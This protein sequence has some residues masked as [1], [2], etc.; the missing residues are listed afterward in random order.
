MSITLLI[1]VIVIAVILLVL[2][3]LISRP[4]AIGV[5]REHFINEWNDIIA[6]SKDNKSRPLSIVHA[7][8]LL[9]EALRC[10]GY[11]GE[12]MAERLV[13]AKNVIRQRESVWSAHKMRNKIAHESAFEPSEKQVSQALKAYQSAFKDLGV[14]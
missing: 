9:D 4:A 10:S 8:K 11:K 7:D 6:L 12:T 13:S 5:D 2:L 3:N 1:V 14:W